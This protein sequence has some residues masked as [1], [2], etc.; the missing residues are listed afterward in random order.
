MKQHEKQHDFYSLGIPL[1][2]VSYPSSGVLT[3]FLKKFL[4][5]ETLEIPQ[6][7]VELISSDFPEMERRTFMKNQCCRFSQKKTASIHRSMIRVG[8]ILAFLCAFCVIFAAYAMEL[9]VHVVKYWVEDG[10]IFHVDFE[11]PPYQKFC[12]AAGA[13]YIGF[14]VYYE[15]SR[16]LKE[17]WTFGLAP[18]PGGPATGHKMESHLESYGPQAFCTRFSPCTI[19]DIQ[20][21]KTWCPIP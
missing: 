20:L 8:G 11:V 6:E 5:E 12:H 17:N 19:Q 10:Y 21:V 3:P 15:D 16:S 1:E 4:I 9:Q 14:N 2:P 13:G 18:W 7:P